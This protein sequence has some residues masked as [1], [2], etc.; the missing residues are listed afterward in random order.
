MVLYTILHNSFTQKPYTYTQCRSRQLVH[1][2]WSVL[3]CV[4]AKFRLSLGE[5]LCLLPLLG[6]VGFVIQ[7]PGLLRTKS[8]TGTHHTSAELARHVCTPGRK[9]PHTRTQTPAHPNSDTRTP[10]PQPNTPEHIHPYTRTQ[11]PAD[12]NSDTRTPGPAHQHTRTQTPAHLDPA[13]V[14]MPF[15]SQRRPP[16]AHRRRGFHWRSG[17]I[18]FRV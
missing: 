9:H 10:D 16:G 13:F 15:Q 14:R 6:S 17:D 12:P 5:S 4:S 3:L 7:L 8:S 2:N 18:H 11:T 1:R